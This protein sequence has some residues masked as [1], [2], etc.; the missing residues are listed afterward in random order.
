MPPAPSFLAQKLL[1]A[2]SVP[3]IGPKVDMGQ[4][5]TTQSV[6]AFA[7]VAG[8]SFRVTIEGSMDGLH[9]FSFGSVAGPGIK[10]EA[11]HTFQFIRA[12]MEEVSSGSVT[13]LV[14]YNTA[15]Q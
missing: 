4:M 14:S 12:I 9:W 7:S 10:S 11:Q 1:D 13:V 3:G 15:K 5:T 6:Q 8:A 2:V